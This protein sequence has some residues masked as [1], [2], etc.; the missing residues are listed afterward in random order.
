MDLRKVNETLKKATA[1]FAVKSPRRRHTGSC[2]NIKDNTRCEEAK[3]FGVSRSGYYA[4]LSR[5]L[6]GRGKADRELARLIIQIFEDNHGRH[7][8]P[9]VWQ[10]LC[11]EC[12]QRTSRKRAE[13]L[14]RENGV[15][16]RGKKKRVNTAAR[17]TICRRRRIY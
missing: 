6:S 14:M 8:S 1:I 15:R 9:R 5:E 16:A 2:G 10:E 12:R 7:G 3:T 4:R 11:Y 13:H 17:N